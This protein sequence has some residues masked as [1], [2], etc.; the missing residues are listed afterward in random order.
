MYN[1]ITKKKCDKCV[2]K[3]RYSEDVTWSDVEG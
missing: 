2:V 3:T 1:T